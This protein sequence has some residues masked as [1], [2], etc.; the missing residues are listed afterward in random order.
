MN[1]QRTSKNCVFS[2]WNVT[3]LLTNKAELWDQHSWLCSKEKTQPPAQYL[4]TLH[5]IRCMKK[6]LCFS[7]VM[8][9]C[10][11][12]ILVSRPFSESKQQSLGFAVLVQS[13]V[14][15]YHLISIHLS[16][17]AFSFTCS[18]LHISNSLVQGCGSVMMRK[19]LRI[20]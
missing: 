5:S 6:G 13:R 1:K 8:R 7:R 20:T 16:Q 14:S 12:R 2:V 11:S 4:K 19:G 15:L 18:V 9:L 10:F 3:Q 17:R